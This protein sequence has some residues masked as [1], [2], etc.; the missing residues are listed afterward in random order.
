M[1][2][3]YSQSYGYQVLELASGTASA[4]FN[5]PSGTALALAAFAEPLGTGRECFFDK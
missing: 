5:Y 1:K 4:A 3:R 2:K